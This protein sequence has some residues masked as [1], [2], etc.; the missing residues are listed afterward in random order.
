MKND[1]GIYVL[2][3]SMPSHIF[4]E[5]FLESLTIWFQYNHFLAVQ[6]DLVLADKAGP[7]TFQIS[8]EKKKL[9]NLGFLVNHYH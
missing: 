9:V 5:P 8:S 1:L 3:R 2:I 6:M 4:Y 7:M